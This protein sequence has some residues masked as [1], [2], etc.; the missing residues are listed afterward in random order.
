MIVKCS[1][2]CQILSE[3]DFDLHICDNPIKDYKTIQVISIQD[4][5]HLNKKIMMAWGIDGILYTFE[6][7]PR[8]PIP[9]IV[10]LNRRK[11]TS[12]GGNNKTD[13][14]V[15]EPRFIRLLYWV[16]GSCILRAM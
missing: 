3:T 5:S 12:L 2:C 7:A 1:H 8:K 9:L 14:D 13:E 16:M 4:L 6:V 11:V 10:P 15:P